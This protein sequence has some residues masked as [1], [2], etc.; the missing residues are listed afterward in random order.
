MSKFLGYS[1]NYTLMDLADITGQKQ[2]IIL[3]WGDEKGLVFS[4]KTFNAV[5][6]MGCFD[7]FENITK[8]K[9]IEY[10]PEFKILDLD[11]SVITA[12]RRKR[13]AFA[14]LF[15]VDGW[16]RADWYGTP[17][18]II[19]SSDLFV[20]VDNWLKFIKAQPELAK[21]LNLNTKRKPGPKDSKQQQI[22][23]DLLDKL[24]T[25]KITSAELKKCNQKSLAFDYQY[26][27]SSRT[28]IIK[29][30]DAAIKEFEKRSQN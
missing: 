24:E 27:A 5:L 22:K 14:S 8:Y 30:R 29:A 20:T 12:I 7:D 17:P 1:E 4:Y 21:E 2:V 26:I 10:G 18:P 11:S 6:E 25:R 3:S 19:K 16:D 23:N 9:I 28:T 15:S 13:E